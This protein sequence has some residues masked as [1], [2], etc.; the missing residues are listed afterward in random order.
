MVENTADSYHNKRIHWKAPF[1]MASGLII[2]ILSALLHHFFY[3]YWDRK[4][5]HDGSQQQWVVRGGTAFAFAVN[6]A[7]AVATGTA[8]VQVLWLRLRTKP[9]SIERIDSMFGILSHAWNF[10]HVK[11][12]LGAPVLAIPAIITW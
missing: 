10:H 6:T 4:N 12:W 7:F 2:G 1:L 9:T 3:S 5:V 8:Y 11:F